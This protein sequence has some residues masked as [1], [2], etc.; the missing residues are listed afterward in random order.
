MRRRGDVHDVAPCRRLAAGEVD[1]QAAQRRRLA[2]HARPFS[3]GQL[4]AGPRQFDGVG[5]VGAAQRAA[6]GELGEERK[7]RVHGAF[8]R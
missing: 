5:A 3:G 4:G 6:M 1:L 7:G 8:M 2:E